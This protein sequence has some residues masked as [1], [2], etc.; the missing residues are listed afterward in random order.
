MYTV[1]DYYKVQM[2]KRG[3]KEEATPVITTT[4]YDLIA[5][6]QDVMT[7]DEDEQVVAAVVHMLASGR[8]KLRQDSTGSAES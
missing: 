7:F 6:L 5:A 1:I 8:L 2:V 4:L 3:V